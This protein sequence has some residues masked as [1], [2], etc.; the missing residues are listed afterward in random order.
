VSKKEIN[1]LNYVEKMNSSP[2]FMNIAKSLGYDKI[3]LQIL[4][5]EETVIREFTSHHKDGKILKVE[6]GLKNPELT[7]RI[8]E[9]VMKDLVSE[10]EQA[11][12]EKHPIEAAIKYASKVEMPLLIKLKLLKILSGF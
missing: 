2:V 12:I 5:S 11:W 1:Y 8:G 6:E 10:E 9:D 4:N 3:G 7:V